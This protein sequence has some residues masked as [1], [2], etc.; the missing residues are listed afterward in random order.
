MNGYFKKLFKYVDNWYQV[1]QLNEGD[2]I[3]SAET[4]HLKYIQIRLSGY[5]Y[6]IKLSNK[7]LIQYYMSYIFLWIQLFAINVHIQFYIK[8]R[9]V[10]RL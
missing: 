7:S 8:D 2:F 10:F 9:I 4:C 1:S 3:G 6:K 5:I